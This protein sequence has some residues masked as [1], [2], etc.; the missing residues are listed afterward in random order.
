MNLSKGHMRYR[1]AVSITSI[2]LLRPGELRF[3]VRLNGS[4]S[5]THIVNVH[6]APSLIASEELIS[7]A[8]VSPS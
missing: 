7:D 4:H 6:D 3:D 8:P 5:A 1:A 2:P